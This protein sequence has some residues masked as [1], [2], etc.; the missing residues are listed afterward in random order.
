MKSYWV[1]YSE[2]VIPITDQE[3]RLMRK[4][5]FGLL[6]LFFAMADTGL[7]AQNANVQDSMALVDL[8]NST[9]GPGWVG[10]TNWLTGPVS[11]WFQVA[12]DNNGRVTYVF[13]ANCN[14]IGTL[15]TTLNKLTALITLQIGANQ[16]SGSIPD[17]TGMTALQILNLNSNQ[18]TGNLPTS[19]GT[20][21]SLKYF[22]VNKNQLSGSIPSLAN[23]T[24]LSEIDLSNNQ[25]SG[26][27]P[28]LANLNFLHA[29][30]LENNKFSGPFPVL[31]GTDTL[32]GINLSN[33]NFSGGIPASIGTKTFLGEFNVSN[34]QFSGPFPSLANLTLLGTLDL[35][36][37]N[38]SGS[39][40]V[41]P[42]P[43]DIIDLRLSHNNFSGLLP[44]NLGSSIG[45]ATQYLDLDHNQFTGDIPVAIIGKGIE[46]VDLSNNLFAAPLN[47]ISSGDIGGLILDSN[48]YDFTGIE[49]IVSNGSVG[50]ITY[51]P[52]FPVIHVNYKTA[53]N[54]MSVSCG[55]TLMY[56]SYAWYKDGTLVTTKTADSTFNPSGCG[57]YWV[58]MTNAIANQ[59]ILYSDTFSITVTNSVTIA[60]SANNICSGANV[61]FTAT[62]VNGGV[63]P[64]YQWQVNGTNAGTNSPTFSSTTLAN[65]DA[66]TVVLT[67]SDGCALPVKANSNN[68]TMIVKSLVTPDFAQVAPVCVGS[69]A[70]A[71][72][73]TSPNGVTGTWTPANI[74]VSK[75]GT[76]TY[77]F[78]PSAGS[79]GTKTTM[80]VEVNP[81]P[82]VKTG[83][84]QTITAGE[85]A[86][87]TATITGVT[88]SDI[89]D[90]L[91]SPP[92]GLSNPAI[93]DPKASPAATTTYTLNVTTTAGCKGSGSE[94]ITVQASVL[95][96]LGIPNVFSPN[97]DGINDTWI[98]T[99]ITYYP[100]AEVSVFNRYGQLVY[101]TQGAYK[102]WDGNYNGKKVPFGTY[103]YI[104]DTKNNAK[105]KSGSITI[106]R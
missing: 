50:S 71:L 35:S 41:L 32:S 101:Q 40:P 74:D 56:N 25:F 83:P 1:F 52:Q 51:A 11:T 46:Y 80:D 72:G 34:N 48:K 20:L 88:E 44:S 77:S 6:I 79:C 36:Y 30:D 59:L 97:G 93:V 76:A 94:T 73:L 69:P 23:L 54:L 16:L 57:K 102:P 27:I 15:P 13:L 84:D 98:I 95:P 38:F 92:D 45:E 43:N 33:N 29:L 7:Y 3:D 47:L 65:N 103:Y 96:P 66:I 61:T 81:L 53:T 21:P 18:L 2:K 87:L 17:L 82:V 14:L 39:F 10:I 85:T 49:S 89:S 42:T 67:T 22:Y 64:A 58:Q 106:L 55:G 86:D 63:T 19:I 37:N 62:P 78:T 104:I 91:W 8:Y 24:N 12:L 90:Y 28:S 4:I 99:N 68:I 70:P 5:I 26:P 100:D 9:N 105:K 60:G 31:S 75:A